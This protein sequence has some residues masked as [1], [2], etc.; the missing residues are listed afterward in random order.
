MPP[1]I[2]SFNSAFNP[3]YHRSQPTTHSLIIKLLSTYVRINNISKGVRKKNLYNQ[4][5]RPLEGR[6]DH[7]SAKIAIFWGFLKKKQGVL[8]FDKELKL[9]K[10][11]YCWIIGGGGLTGGF[12]FLLSVFLRKHLK[13]QL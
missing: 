4:R 8:K 7:L 10:I 1:F 2:P 13:L 5:Q 9:R 12:R 11:A 3:T 6:V